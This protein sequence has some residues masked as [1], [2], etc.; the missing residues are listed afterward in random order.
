M[1]HPHPCPQLGREGFIF[2]PTRVENLC[3]IYYSLKIHTGFSILSTKRSDTVFQMK[4][5]DAFFFFLLET[6]L[7]ASGWPIICATAQIKPA[8]SSFPP[9]KSI[10]P[11]A[12]SSL[13]E[14]TRK[15]L[16]RSDQHEHR[17]CSSK[18]WPGKLG[19]G[20]SSLT[21]ANHTGLRGLPHSRS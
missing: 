10:K 5:A 1:P 21:W 7:R 19:G 18:D 2:I 16:I 3:I 20:F 8:V 9:T 12:A 14:K 6:N 4:Y 17:E 11:R 13:K 15:L